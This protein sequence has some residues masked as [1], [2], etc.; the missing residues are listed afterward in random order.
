MINFSSADQKELLS[1]ARSSIVFYLKNNEYMKMSLE[2]KDKYGK[3]YGV[4]TT[5]KKAGELRGCIGF[6]IAR[7][8]LWKSVLETSVE[9]ALGDPRFP[10]VH[11]EELADLTVELSV[12]SPMKKV[13]SYKDIILGRH[14]VLV[15][16]GFSQGVFLPQV[17]TETGW[18]LPT[19]LSHLCF[20]KAGLPAE[21]WKDPS[22]ELMTFEAFVF[23]E[24]R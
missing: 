19:F 12:L 8:P 21:A 24:E 10:D 17:A 23:S 5:L 7:D 6:I 20:G 3:P 13:N 15:K 18:D 14:G 9:S 11:P 4:F 2:L 16:K 1:L 22:T